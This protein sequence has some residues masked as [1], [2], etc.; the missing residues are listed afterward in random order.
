MITITEN[1]KLKLGF[2]VQ[3]FFVIGLHH[4]DKALL[5]KILIYFAVGNITKEK[6]GIIKYKVSSVKDLRVIIVT[7][8][9]KMKFACLFHYEY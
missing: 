4:R 2:Q 3:L 6:S 5:E 9:N 1:K 7:F 8:L